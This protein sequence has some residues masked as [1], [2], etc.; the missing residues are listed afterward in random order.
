VSQTGDTYDPYPT[1]D[2]P[3]GTETP[4]PGGHLHVRFA[5]DTASVPGARRFVVDGLRAWAM[6]PLV[7]DAEL[8]ISELAGN[9]ALHSVSTFMRIDVLRTTDG[10]LLS[11]EDDGDVPLHVVVPRADY[12]PARGP[13]E[14][15]L[16]TEPTT[17]R[18]L[19]IVGFLASTWGVER[20]PQGKRIWAELGA[21]GDAPGAVDEAS[22]GPAPDVGPLPPDW[23]LVR[24]AGCPVR[25]SLRQDE[26]LDEL[27][28]EFQLL[29]T[30]QGNDR[31]LALARQIE[32]LLNAPAHAR[33][34]GRRQ[35]QLADRAGR[36]HVDI[37]MA[38]PRLASTWVRALQ[39]VV[40]AADALCAD[41][42]LLTLA[43][44]EDLRLLRAW[45][46]EELVAQIETGAAP[47]SWD[48]WLAGCA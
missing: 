41:Q 37:D 32:G 28:R 13:A 11:V 38:M 2:R 25:L 8:C 47:R 27:V 44:S 3:G 29:A 10:V 6:D 36:T 15:V 1:E 22:D 19:G 39:E 43:S 12:G 23:V 17:G 14:H 46:T 30:D 9:A 21:A 5:A 7:D 18:G 48:D 20:T 42:R 45:M 35:A 24:L 34:T 26:H 40:L 33:F 16:D 31:S 4:V